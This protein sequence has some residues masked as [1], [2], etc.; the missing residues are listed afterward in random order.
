M[1]LAH[2]F[3][4]HFVIFCYFVCWKYELNLEMLWNKMFVFNKQNVLLK[5][6]SE[7]SACKILL[8]PESTSYYKRPTHKGCDSRIIRYYFNKWVISKA[9]SYIT[10]IKRSGEIICRRLPKALIMAGRSQLCLDDSISKSNLWCL[11]FFA[12]CDANWK[13]FWVICVHYF[14]VSDKQ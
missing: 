11:I 10:R 8:F 1:V 4:D 7:W 5:W 2:S 13:I 12:L 14:F 9:I 3:F 6:S